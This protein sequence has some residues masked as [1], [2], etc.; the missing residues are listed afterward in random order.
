ME[1][2]TS[3]GAVC[4]CGAVVGCG[5]QESTGVGVISGFVIG[6]RTCRNLNVPAV[7]A[8]TPGH[9]ASA[10]RN[11]SG[12]ET[13]IIEIAA[14]PGAVQIAAMVL[15]RSGGVEKV[16]EKSWMKKEKFRSSGVR[17]FRSPEV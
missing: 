13:R 12:P 17:K 9:S 3:V 15:P 6:A 14:L 1:A 2:P 8:D 4:A 7:I 11:A 5:R 16:K 10:M